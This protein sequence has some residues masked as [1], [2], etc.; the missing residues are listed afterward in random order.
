MSTSTPSAVPSPKQHLKF[1]E[2]VGYAFGDLACN[3]YWGIFSTFL[4]YFYTDVFGLSAGMVGTLF[5]VSRLWN[6]LNDPIM[7]VI[8]DR[9]QSKHGHFR[10]WILWVSVPIAIIG[11]L[12]F[13]TPDFSPAVKLVYAWIVYNL[14]MMAYTAI[15]IPYSALMGVMTSN[16]QER[17]A[18]SSYRFVGAFIG[19]LI[20]NAFLLKIVAATGGGDEATGWQWA[21]TIF[22]AAAVLLFLGTFYLTKE[23]VQPPK[24]QVT[25]LRHDLKDLVTNGPWLVIL[26]VGSVFLIG[27]SVRGSS[28]MYYFKYFTGDQTFNFLGWTVAETSAGLAAT[29]LTF[30]SIGSLLGVMITPLWTKLMGK[31]PAFIFLG[32]AGAIMAGV[33]YFLPPTAM[34]AI[35]GLHFAISFLMGPM[36]P[37]IWSIYTDC[38]DYSEW[39]NGR[40]A[41]GLVM[42][43]S[44]FAQG[45]GWTVA[46]AAGGWLLHAFGFIANQEQTATAIT[47]IVLM[48]SLIPAGLTLFGVIL[49][50]FYPLNEKRLEEME[51][52]LTAR[53]LAEA[54]SDGVSGQ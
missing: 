54:A 18:L 1:T 40:R 8:A 45:M 47:G 10:P 20:I 11:I 2:K 12:N 36:S 52:D 13:S 43:A 9:T 14:M 23:R 35:F 39:K 17:T 34:V 51:R 15:N 19:S 29:F 31:K 32:I 37:I 28:V 3:F 48:M 6:A 49:L 38:A 5:F 46:G 53:R 24:S 50:V 42:S 41:T 4:M 16:P 26:L 33:Y 22:G 27:F 21:L 30:G 44:G 25:N 7:G